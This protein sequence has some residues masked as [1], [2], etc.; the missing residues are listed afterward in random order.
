MRA[1]PR[2]RSVTWNGESTAPPTRT[3][4]ASWPMRWAWPG[5]HACGSWWRRAD[6]EAADVLAARGGGPGA[7]AA[8]AT[9]ALPRDIAAFTG[10]QAD[11]ARLVGGI[12]ALAAAG[13]VVG[14]HAVGGMA[15]VGKTTFAVHAA[16]RLARA[17]PDGQFFLPLHAHTA[18]HRPVDP[19]DALAS[20]LLTA[21]VPAAQIPPGLDARGRPVAGPG[22]GQEDP[23]AAG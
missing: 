7:F 8:A 10:R 18:G 6:A 5:R 22:G 14:I 1:C 4:P 11:L 19:A 23:A 21:G 16:H 12:D 2:G 3:P 20:L 17:F 9:R 13:G 15:G